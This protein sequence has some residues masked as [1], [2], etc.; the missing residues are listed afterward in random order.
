[1]KKTDIIDLALK[2][3]G[4]YVIIVAL[5]S[6]KDLHY[7]SNIFSQND[8]PSIDVL[9]L[10]MFFGGVLITFLIGY[11]LIFKSTKVAQKIIK[12]DI[13]INLSFD[14]NY[15]NILEIALIIIGLYI[16]IFRLP[17]LISSI[18][19]F[20]TY[21][22]DDMRAGSEFIEHDITNVIHYLLG[23]ILVTNSKS[24]VGWIIRINKKNFKS[25]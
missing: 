24:I 13:E 19:H 10:I 3:F 8:P 15:K 18:H 4:I 6:F 9:S 7:L 16:L 2:I 23:Y 11:F 1:M 21:L 20:I 12:E 22:L 17:Y 25:A 14:T 5:L